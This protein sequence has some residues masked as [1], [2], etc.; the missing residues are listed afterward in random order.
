MRAGKMD[1][2]VTIESLTDAL[3]EFGNPIPAWTPLSTVRAQIVQASTDQFIRDYGASAETVIVFRI[4]WLDGV[5]ADCRIQYNN[6]P[7]DIIEL[8]EIGRRRGL[9][10]RCK[11]RGTG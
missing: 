5:T 10:I 8:K 4:R 7:H 2:T 6:N 3:D 1:R 9:E 11:G